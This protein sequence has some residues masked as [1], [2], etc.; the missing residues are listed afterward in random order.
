MTLDQETFW[1]L[2]QGLSHQP[3][4]TIDLS[5]KKN[6]CIEVGNRESFHE[7]TTQP[8]PSV[9]RWFQTCVDVETRR[10]PR[11]PHPECFHLLC[12]QLW[13]TT[14]EDMRFFTQVVWVVSQMEWADRVFNHIN[15]HFRLSVHILYVAPQ[16]TQY[17]CGC[18]QFGQMQR[19]MV[20]KTVGC[21]CVPLSWTLLGSGNEVIPSVSYWPGETFYAYW[22]LTHDTEKNSE[23][24]RLVLNLRFLVLPVDSKRIW[25][26][27][28][29]QPRSLCRP[30][31]S[32]L[33][34][35]SEW[36]C[37]DVFFHLSLQFVMFG[38]ETVRPWFEKVLFHPTV[39]TRK[40]KFSAFGT[41]NIPP[42]RKGRELVG[43]CR[44]VVLSQWERRH[45]GFN[46]EL[47][48]TA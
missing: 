2:V 38:A 23:N 25:C 44:A 47:V 34:K 15:F 14:D 41:F 42:K 11:H 5:L 6:A 29:G 9:S 33:Q 31:E 36:I 24:W 1:A 45:D 17:M 21:F 30:V 32:P 3:P 35:C 46:F 37:S 13:C 28:D 22:K 7:G 39:H 20:E 8:F 12:V 26:P 40:K 43:V 19:S 27:C 48:F 4:V 18:C 10:N 16:F